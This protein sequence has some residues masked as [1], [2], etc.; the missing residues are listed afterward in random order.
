MFRGTG[1]A[2]AQQFA[3]RRRDKDDVLNSNGSALRGVT[4]W[5]DGDR[6]KSASTASSCSRTATTTS[7]V[8]K[9]EEQRSMPRQTRGLDR[10][11]L[12]RAVLHLE[13]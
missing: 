11:M 12:L 1:H 6:L 2:G 7:A 9:A 8:A 13:Q 4:W 3:Q 10:C 5:V